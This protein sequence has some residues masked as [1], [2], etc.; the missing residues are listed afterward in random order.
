MKPK[1]IA[2]IAIAMTLLLGASAHQEGPLYLTPVAPVV[3]A[4]LL[5]QRYLVLAEQQELLGM[6]LR[7]YSPGAARD[8]RIRAEVYRAV[9]H[10]IETNWT[11]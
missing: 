8:F 6:L 2:I 11:F 4:D 10:D 5:V 9:A 7:P 1:L 3:R